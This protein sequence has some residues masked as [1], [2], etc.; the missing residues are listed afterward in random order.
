LVRKNLSDHGKISVRGEYPSITER[1]LWNVKHQ[2]HGKPSVHEKS[3]VSTGKSQ[4][5]GKIPDK[6]NQL[7]H[8]SSYS[9]EERDAK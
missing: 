6:T 1:P 4:Q 2:L 3:S 9:R 7:E 8:I 5:H